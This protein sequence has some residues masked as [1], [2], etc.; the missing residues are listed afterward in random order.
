MK[1]TITLLFALA[2]TV[3]QSFA[4]SENIGRQHLPDVELQKMDGSRVNISS[5]GKNEKITVIAFWATW[6]AP[7]KR[8]LANISDIYDDWREDYNLEVLAISIDD[9]RN[10]GRVRSYVNSQYWDFE[11]LLDTNQDM[12][13][14]LNFQTIPFTVLVNQDG[15]I[16]YTHSGYV[17]GDEFILEEKIKNLI[18]N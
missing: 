8:E 2:M 13:R 17:E 14:H 12:K 1:I 6:C 15:R 11:V 18:K 9:T 5:F 7:C 4:Q 10:V 3:S 16:V